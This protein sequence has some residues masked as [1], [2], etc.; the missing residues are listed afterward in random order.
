MSLSK[1]EMGMKDHGSSRKM[2]EQRVHSQSPTPNI[3]TNPQPQEGFWNAHIPV[4]VKYLIKRGSVS[5]FG[6]NLGLEDI[7]Q[8]VCHPKMENVRQEFSGLFFS[9][10]LISIRE[11]FIVGKSLLAS[12]R[13]ELFFIASSSHQASGDC[14]VDMGLFWAVRW[15]HSVLFNTMAH[16]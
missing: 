7:Q 5:Y 16:R 11:E 8:I 1:A 12:E 15:R 13:T 14:L 2:W 4:T 10:S 3:I 9:N 6:E